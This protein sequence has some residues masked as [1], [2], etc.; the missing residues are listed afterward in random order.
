MKN[1]TSEPAMQ[2]SDIN[3]LRSAIALLKQHDGQYI[4]TDHIVDPNAELAGVY[5][6]IGAGG[7]VTQATSKSTS[8]TLNKPS[9]Q[10]TTHN[11]ALAAGATV[12]FTCLNSYVSATS[13]VVVSG[14]Y[15]GGASYPANYQIDATQLAA[16]YFTVRIK[17]LSAGSL[18]DALVIQFNV[19]TGAT[20]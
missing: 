17:N 9:G 13:C 4:E 19:H 3:D 12:T 6:H 8:V 20:S 11:S 14:I 15:A 10:I 16:G 5:R 2:A 7:T 18:S 1:Q